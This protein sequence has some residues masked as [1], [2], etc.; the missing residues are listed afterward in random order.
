MAYVHGKLERKT[1]RGSRSFLSFFF[2]SPKRHAVSTSLPS[3]APM[4]TNRTVAPKAFL[5]SSHSSD[6]F[7]IAQF[8]VKKS[9]EGAPYVCPRCPSRV[10]A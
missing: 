8:H 4:D 3:V 6:G 1:L 2:W 10:D 7:C 5:Y 9:Q